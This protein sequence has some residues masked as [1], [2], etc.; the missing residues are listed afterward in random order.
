MYVLTPDYEGTQNF[1]GTLEY[2]GYLHVDT[3]S[4]N[5]PHTTATLDFRELLLN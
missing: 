5:I 1:Y 2:S 4:G 3:G